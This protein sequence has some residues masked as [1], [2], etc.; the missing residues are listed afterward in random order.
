M[1]KTGRPM[2][3]HSRRETIIASL[4]PPPS[5]AGDPFRKRA[6]ARNAASLV[7]LVQ[8]AVDCQPLCC[9]VLISP[10][11]PAAVVD[12][13]SACP[14]ESAHSPRLIALDRFAARLNFSTLSPTAPFDRPKS[15]NTCSSFVCFALC[16]KATKLARLALLVICSPTTQ[17]TATSAPHHHIHSTMANAYSPTTNTDPIVQTLQEYRK[18]FWQS[19]AH[20]SE[21][22]RQHLWHN[23]K[24]ELVSSLDNGPFLSTEVHPHTVPRSMSLGGHVSA[25]PTPV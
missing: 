7:R 5:S 19:H 9:A 2:A 3:T 25:R 14:F 20:L 11:G 16:T 13:S 21:E 10:L 6:A 18:A 8:L 4:W 17:Q 12:V 1:E 15:I 24:A 23:R 22:Q